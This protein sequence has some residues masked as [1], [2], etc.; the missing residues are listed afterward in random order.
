MYNKTEAELVK[1]KK[2]RMWQDRY[3]MADIQIEKFG[4]QEKKSKE[5]IISELITLLSPINEANQSEM[6]KKLGKVFNITSSELEG[7][8]FNLDQIDNF[9]ENDKLFYIWVG[10]SKDGMVVVVGKTSFQIED[11][12]HG[13]LFFDFNIWGSG[14]QRI[15]LKQFAKN[16]K[17]ESLLVELEDE[18]NRYITDAIVIPVNVD[19]QAEVA[20]IERKI[21]EQ[22]I[23][24]KYPLVNYYS[25]NW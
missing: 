18:L 20:I 16:K 4:K 9:E 21:G 22:L 25:H 6:K 24:A 15:L 8:R 19:N 12:L 7:M 14:T 2:P 3:D 5:T 23:D 11:K 1:M 13:D 17:Y 10:L